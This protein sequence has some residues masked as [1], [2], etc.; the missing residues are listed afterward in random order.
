M[1][2]SITVAHMRHSHDARLRAQGIRC[3]SI[4][5]APAAAYTVV[6]CMGGG[7][8]RWHFKWEVAFGGGLLQRPPQQQKTQ[9]TAD[10][11]RPFGIH[12]P[13]LP[14]ARIADACATRPCLSLFPANPPTDT[15]YHNQKRKKGASYLRVYKHGSGV[16]S[17][18]LHSGLLVRVRVR[19][20]FRYLISRE[21][22]DTGDGQRD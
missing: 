12:A 20:G 5:A 11:R 6:F 22:T 15:P 21:G 2:A 19:L 17:R 8:L 1:P 3:G 4:R 18:N 13:R 10:R 9:N 14:N 16:L 7:L